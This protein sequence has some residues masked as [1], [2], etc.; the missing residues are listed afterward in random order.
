[1]QNAESDAEGPVEPPR[2]AGGGTGA[3]GDARMRPQRPVLDLTATE[4]AAA[5]AAPDEAAAAQTG[6]DTGK[7]ETAVPPDSGGA[8]PPASRSGTLVA[9]TVCGAAAGALVAAAALWIW[10]SQDQAGGL[11]PLAS[12]LDRVEAGMQTLS[13]QAAAGEE[14]LRLARPLPGQLAKMEATAK[15]QPAAADPAFDKQVAALADTTQALQAQVGDLRQR[16]DQAAKDAAAAR[17]TAARSAGSSS[18]AASSAASEA[19]ALARRVQALEASVQVLRAHMETPPRDAGARFATAAL[20][21]RDAVERGRPYAAELSVLEVRHA[22]AGK[23]APLRAF[24]A[25]C[26]PGTDSLA[27]AL[28]AIT[29]A[30]K[31]PAAASSDSVLAR[32]RTAASG[33]VRITPAGAPTASGSAPA[34]LGAIRTLAARGDLA[35]AAAAVEKLPEA[36]RAPFASWVARV[37]ARDAALAAARRL[38]QESLAT[39]GQNSRGQGRQ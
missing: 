5:A 35:G 25:N 30:E 7:A 21:L 29:A 18:A 28:D 26:V 8:G 6:T 39:L 31:P 38:A 1:M 33:L 24:A 9:A 3:T 23:L 16:L 4:V 20:A 13:A 27:R 19:E 12:R 2:G 11:Q 22:D 15:A 10:T 17:D 32:L 37:R 34:S 36:E 14:A